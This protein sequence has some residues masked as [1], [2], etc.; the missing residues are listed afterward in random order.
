MY[1]G[2]VSY[3]GK[4]SK[5][6]VT[7][8]LQIGLDTKVNEL[9]KLSTQI[10]YFVEYLLYSLQNKKKIHL[11]IWSQIYWTWD[12]NLVV[13]GLSTNVGTRSS[14]EGTADRVC[15]GEGGG[16]GDGGGGDP[17]EQE[18]PL[19][20]AINSRCRSS[21]LSLWR[22]EFNRSRIFE[23][24]AP[25]HVDSPPLPSRACGDSIGGHVA[26]REGLQGGGGST[27]T[28]KEQL[29]LPGNLVFSRPVWNDQRESWER[30]KLTLPLQTEQP[31]DWRCSLWWWLNLVL[32]GANT[33]NAALL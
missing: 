9:N 26:N 10:L 4:V 18:P 25:V 3:F 33:L 12:T 29:W 7:T 28:H 32:S 27:C 19:P 8:N 6:F 15:G 30:L 2:L 16:G 22:F 24:Q 21:L 13:I 17:V 14:A 11:A 23:G 1:L 20:W 5:Q 31:G